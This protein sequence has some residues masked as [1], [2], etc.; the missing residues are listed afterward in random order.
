MQSRSARH[1]TKAPSS[2]SRAHDL[3]PSCHS[4]CVGITQLANP[5][6]AIANGIVVI[7]QFDEDLRGVPPFVVAQRSP[8]HTADAV[9]TTGEFVVVLHSWTTTSA[10]V[11]PSTNHPSAPFARHCVRWRQ[12][13]R[14]SARTPW[15]AL[16]SGSELGSTSIAE[17]STFRMD[18]ESGSPQVR[19]DRVIPQNRTSVARSVDKVWPPAL[20]PAVAMSDN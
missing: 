17:T 8:R 6:V 2:V 4:R 7:L 18:Q 9:G 15:A 12:R 3:R 13:R 14:L 20:R 1:C 5:D 11:H 19:F 16:S 10:C